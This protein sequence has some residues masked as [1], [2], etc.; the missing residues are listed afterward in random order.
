MQ[1]GGE[2]FCSSWKGRLR[3]PEQ[4]VGT[5]W[6][7]VRGGLSNQIAQPL[8]L[9]HGE[10]DG[11]IAGPSRQNESRSSSDRLTDWLPA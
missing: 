9:L 3:V 11:V 2:L 1:E 5:R 8:G 7:V 4:G 10:R 6:V